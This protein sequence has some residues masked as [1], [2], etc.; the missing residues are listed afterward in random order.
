MASQSVQRNN[1]Q[2]ELRTLAKQMQ[3][4]G[5]TSLEE[6][7]ENFRLAFTD[8]A[9]EASGGNQC[10]AAQSLRVH[11]NTV[12]RILGGRGRSRYVKV[13]SLKRGRIEPP[14]DLDEEQDRLAIESELLERYP[15]RTKEICA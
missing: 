1:V 6:A 4:S 5:I 15:P 2:V 13:W 9:V 12:N 3:S 8:A 11:R 14:E 7:E 10:V